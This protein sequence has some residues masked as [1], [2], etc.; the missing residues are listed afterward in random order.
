[1]N[2]E[3]DVDQRFAIY[4]AQGSIVSQTPATMHATYFAQRI[5]ERTAPERAVALGCPPRRSC[6]NPLSSDVVSEKTIY[7]RY[8]R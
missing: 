8:W 1:M 5:S 2:C 4:D 7:A 6:D 3:P